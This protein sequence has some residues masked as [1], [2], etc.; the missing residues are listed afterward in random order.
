MVMHEEQPNAIYP[1]VLHLIT[2]DA[3]NGI[4][5]Q[6]WC[7]IGYLN[8]RMWNDNILTTYFMRCAIDANCNKFAYLELFSIYI[9]GILA[10]N[11][12]HLDELDLP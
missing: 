9:F 8:N 4:Q 10:Q 6:R 1:L 11:Y 5:W 12:G 2:K 7:N 3:C